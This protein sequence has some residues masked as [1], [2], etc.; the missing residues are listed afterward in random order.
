MFRSGLVNT[1]VTHANKKVFGLAS[2]SGAHRGYMPPR[3]KTKQKNFNH[4]ESKYRKII[5]K[6]HMPHFIRNYRLTQRSTR[7]TRCF[8]R[9]PI[10]AARQAW[11]EFFKFYNCVL[12]FPITRTVYSVLFFLVISWCFLNCFRFLFLSCLSIIRCSSII[13]G[14][15]DIITIGRFGQIREVISSIV[16]WIKL[17]WLNFNIITYFWTS[18]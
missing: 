9:H 15:I 10:W 6:T 1:L 14:F 17:W 12:N 18:L 4:Q 11:S 3:L 13:F 5:L 7:R 8:W 16:S 2:L